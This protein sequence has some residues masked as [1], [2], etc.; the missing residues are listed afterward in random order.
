MGCWTPILDLTQSSAASPVL[1]CAH[2]SK[3]R[4]VVTIRSLPE[5]HVLESERKCRGNTYMQ[6]E[7]KK[8]T[9]PEHLLGTDK[10]TLCLGFVRTG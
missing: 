9:K 1:R 2:N 6:C 3:E 5:F 10:D 4:L 8:C 7:R